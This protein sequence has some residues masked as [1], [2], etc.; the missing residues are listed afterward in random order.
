MALENEAGTVICAEADNAEE[1]VRL[2]GAEQPDICL[3][4]WDLPGGGAFAV[5]GVLGV[6][7]SSAVIVLA[8]GDSISDFICAINA[9]ALGYVPG[10]TGPEQLR[11]VIRA[12][13]AREAAV[14]RSMVR[15]L[16]VELRAAT[17][18]RAIGITEREAE[19]LAMLRQGHSTAEIARL[20]GRSPVT[21]RRHISDLVHKL[22]VPDRDALVQFADQLESVGQS[23]GGGG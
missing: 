15:D 2:A 3:V 16:M 12:V 18:R 8:V 17:T 9:G 11:R 10:D 6:A 4:G 22:D 1:A 13:V 19:V 23:R 7:P 5:Q 20:M 14:P 21:V